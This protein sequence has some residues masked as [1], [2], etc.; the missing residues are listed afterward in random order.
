MYIYTVAETP[1]LF[2]DLNHWLGNVW[3]RVLPGWCKVKQR[4]ICDGALEQRTLIKGY[5]LT[6]TYLV[7]TYVTPGR[8]STQ[9]V[10]VSGVELQN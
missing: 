9:T 10:E 2:C 5:L 3:F 4:A 6:C 7:F 1:I 8:P